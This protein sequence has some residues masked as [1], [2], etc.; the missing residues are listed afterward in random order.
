M[1]DHQKSGVLVAWVLA[2]HN[3]TQDISLWL[4][5]LMHR[6]HQ[7]DHSWKVNAFMGDDA[8]AEIGALR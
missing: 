7:G 8:L 2:S 5:Q 4:D 1:L 3:T 6:C